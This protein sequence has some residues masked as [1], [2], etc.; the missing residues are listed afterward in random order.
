MEGF[1]SIK[2]VSQQGSI[3]ETRNPTP[4][5]NP[6]DIDYLVYAHVLEIKALGHFGQFELIPRSLRPSELVSSIFNVL[7]PKRLN[8]RTGQYSYTLLF[9]TVTL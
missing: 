2:I 3:C 1:V 5:P 7:S 4:H 8:S 9:P 6:R